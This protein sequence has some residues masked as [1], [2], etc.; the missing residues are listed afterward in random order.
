MKSS[1]P[2]TLGIALLLASYALST[3]AELSAKTTITTYMAFDTP[4]AVSGGATIDFGT[5][6]LEKTAA[7]AANR[8]RQNVSSAASLL[9]TGSATQAINI[10]A[11]NYT[12]T[13]EID[14]KATTCQYG[15]GAPDICKNLGTQPPP[16]TGT[17]LL[18]GM[19][20]STASAIQLASST[21]PSFEISILYN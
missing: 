3:K 14:I 19:T 13:H 6:K 15:T 10:N 9:I 16:G 18:V 2:K 4:L 7:Y 12:N 17:R 20:I 21:T 5:V 1:L 11:G 8:G